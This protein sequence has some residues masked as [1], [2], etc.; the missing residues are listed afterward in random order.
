MTT[1]RFRD[2]Y[3]EFKTTGAAVVPEHEIKAILRDYGLGIPEGKLC[4]SVAEACAYAQE[5]HYPLALKLSSD[6]IL[7][8]TEQN[9]I[10]LGIASEEDLGRNFKE[11]DQAFQARKVPG[12]LG[13]LV[14][15]QT[16]SGTEIIVGLQ[17][18]PAFGLVLLIGLGGIFTD[19][20]QDVV[21]R[22]LPVSKHAIREALHQ[23]KGWP[24]LNGHRGSQTVQVES[25][26]DAIEAIGRFGA[27]YAPFYA[28]VDFNPVIARSDGCTVVDAK[29]VISA[30]EGKAPFSFELP[31]TEFI[32]NFFRPTSV[33]VIGASA[34]PGKIGYAILDS[35]LNLEYQG[36]VYPINPNYPEVLGAKAYPSLSILPEVPALVVI[37]V[38]LALVPGII[39]E[40]GRIGA[41]NAFIV[42]GGGKELGGD[43]ARIEQEIH[44]LAREHRVRIIG[45]NCIGSFD[46]NHRFDSFFYPR[47]RLKRPK[48][49]SIS[50]I[51][52]SGTWG[53]AFLEYAQKIGASKMV[54]Y[55]NRVDVDEG[56]LIAYLADDQD[57]TVVGSYLE[58][59]SS[60]RKF[61]YAAVMAREKGKP[62]VVFKTGRN[63]ISAHAAVSHTGAYG[64]S[65]QV[66]KGLMEAA[67]VILTDSFQELDAACKALALQPP[68]HGS[69]V[70][71]VSNGAG[72]MVNAIDLF[73]HK[74]LELTRLANAS[75]D[76]MRSR[77]SFFYIVENPVD[78]TGSATAADYEFVIETLL[79]DENVDIVMPYFVFQNTP[80]DESIVERL[81]TF[82]RKR[83]KP[84][85][86]CTTPGP[87]SYKMGKELFSIGLPVYT[88]I[89]EWV[90]AASALVKWGSILLKKVESSWKDSS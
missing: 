81:D 63:P 62:V 41:H 26:V 46:G 52:Q 42:S 48:G 60:G 72:P 33:A 55:G 11:M 65:Y 30:R 21:F 34:T 57:T 49:G 28:S 51:T 15:E 50:L 73:P 83:I 59:L 32:E 56:D 74:G 44:D 87:Y 9:G 35:L 25:L 40:M 77:F 12:Y 29:M 14:E 5:L 82:T 27:E 80:L 13:I 20:F 75:F 86:C 67:G 10:R 7:H 90:S 61:L 64:G 88:H 45:P 69:R 23:L 17:H 71:L 43:R 4:T 6:R 37:A 1:D 76:A 24:I 22:L 58:G 68:A 3:Y 2:R 47:E 16:P 54:S 79:L 85:V 39:R 8:K 89:I 38:D 19:L 31:R 36:K 53:C 70:A 84:I 78:V 18:D 66:Y